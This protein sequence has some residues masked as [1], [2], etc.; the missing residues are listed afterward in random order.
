EL[1]KPRARIRFHGPPNSGPW[2]S[3]EAQF[4]S[5]RK[6]PFDCRAHVLHR[7]LRETIECAAPLPLAPQ[8]HGGTRR[9]RRDL[10]GT[11]QDLSPAQDRHMMELASP[12]AAR[13]QPAREGPAHQD[14]RSP[15]RDAVA[16]K[17]VRP[18]L[19]VEVGTGRGRW[20]SGGDGVNFRW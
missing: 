18:R 6:Y 17:M 2:G 7:S 19:G 14:T 1:E 9:S 3:C 20:G 11:K 16:M 12:F 8:A 4:R 15:R 13:R 5:A 10:R